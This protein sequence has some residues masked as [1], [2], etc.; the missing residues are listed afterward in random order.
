MK[1]RDVK[2]LGCLLTLA[3]FL[4]T[5]CRKDLGNYEYR[6]I[7]DAQITDIAEAY[8]A[9]RGLVLSIKPTLTF[10]KDDGADTTKYTYGW[11]IIDQSGSR[12][13]KTQIAKTKFL[14]WAVNFP[15]STTAYTLLYE[16]T[17]V[18]TGLIFRKNTKLNITTNI[19]DGWLVLN[20]I[21]GKTRLDFLNYLTATTDF[22]TYTDVLA[23]QSTL[24]PQGAPKFVYYWFRR[25][26]YTATIY[27]AIAVGTDQATNII[28]T[29]DGTFSKFANISTM[30]SAYSPPP[31][32]AQSITS[33]GA[34]FLAYLYDSNGELFFEN[35]LQGNA[36]GTRVN[37][38]SAA[39]NF[40][41]S[42][43]YAE[44]Y[45]NGI[46]YALMFDM[47]NRRFMEHKSSNTSSSVP[48]PKGTIFTDN[49]V[50]VGNLKMD[51]VYMA[52]T[53]A[54]GSRTYALFKNSSNELFLTTIQCNAST[55]TPLTWNKITTAP[56]MVNATQFAI[57]P[58]EG[59]LMY[60]VGSKIYRYNISDKTNTMVLDM[61]TKKVSLIKY[62]KLTFLT[63]NA[64]YL[65]YA[66]KL[67]VC[68]YDDANPST[69]G[70]MN[71]Y[72][73][74]NLNNALSLYKS[75]TGFGKIVSV[76]YRE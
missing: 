69:T 76:S 23:T 19:A 59:Y 31:H 66:G 27:K 13:T 10:T 71:L 16:V 8:S 7:N 29:Q 43:F 26:P 58:N 9:L 73:V 17:E 55:F 6:E 49:N 47:D 54:L 2:H 72:N 48:V 36:W 46:T 3:I 30:M 56:E 12:V 52:S 41:I 5:A 15:S 75:F 62:Q 40:K 24:V 63:T 61:G 57:D 64:R 22:Q 67:I 33:Q 4:L 50:D 42:P 34:S 14:N 1:N 68:T 65:E 51:L 45:K 18:K 35:V 70:E 53:P 60:L 39:V 44:A 38:T 11:Y 20:D 21:N 32:Y 37:K 74:P 28:N 25:D